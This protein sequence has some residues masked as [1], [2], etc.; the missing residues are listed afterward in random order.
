[1]CSS[2]L[3]IEAPAGLIAP[4]GANLV[5]SAL[6]D[7]AFPMRSVTIDIEETALCTPD[8]LAAAERLR[9]RGW[10]VGLRCAENCPLPLGSR[11]RSLFS[12]VLAETPADLSPALG[13]ADPDLRPL[14][15]RI[16]AAAAAGIATTALGVKSPA[17]AG[18]L[19]ALGFERG[20]GPG[21][22]V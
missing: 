18:L 12:E 7:A 20:A 15:R 21:Y 2:D 5:D 19:A 9:A 17:H 8:G 4:G 14:T 1:M 22:P 6:R 13:L 11:S 16:R 10:G 3:S